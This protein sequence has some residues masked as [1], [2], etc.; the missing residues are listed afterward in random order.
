MQ[1]KQATLLELPSAEGC[2]EVTAPLGE[3]AERV[4]KP[5]FQQI[6]REQLSW[7]SMIVE[8]LIGEGHPARAIW[9]FVGGLDLSGYTRHVRAVEGFAGRPLLNPQ[10]LISLWIYS[11]SQGVGSARSIEKLCE[12]DPA[13]Q[14]LTGME[15]VNAHSLSDF[16]VKH[17]KVLKGLFVQIL[18]LLSAE[19]L[20]TLERVTQD[21]TKI[22]ASAASDSFKGK[23]RIEKALA[24]A[25]QQVTAVDQLSEEESSRRVEKARQRAC[26]E[27][28]DRLER[29]LKQFERS[30]SEGGVKGKEKPK[31]SVTDPEA[32][33]MKQPDGGFAPSFNVQLNT[34][35]ANGLIVA[36]GVTQEGSDINQLT[37]GIERI[38]Q[39]LGTTPKQV[40]ADGGYVSRDNIV[41]MESRQVDFIA[42][43]CDEVGKGKSNYAV[44][45]ISA[46][47]ESSRFIYDAGANS[48]LCPQGKPL[49]YKTK[50][51][52]DSK[53]LYKYCA[54]LADCQN[55][56]AKG[57]C[58][59]GNKKSGR[60]VFRIE[61]L[62]QI[63]QFRQKMET[64]GAKEIYR[65]RSQIA[66]TPN[67]WI[68]A[69]FKLRQFSVRGLKKVGMESIWV[70]L[71]YN[72]C[73][74]IRICWR[75]DNLA[76]KAIV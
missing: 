74:W 13:Y 30:R 58:C 71:T 5:R 70:C 26:R 48:F 27:R 55:C 69:K 12:H 9:D 46:D 65:K 45:G 59:P 21:G 2:S 49:P 60:A 54:N 73:Q 24:A 23:D 39:N 67:L 37:S 8:R 56:V 16:R 61:E 75:K 1:D 43:Q 53:V 57:Q 3:Y 51:E 63:L 36:V 25:R 44:R 29:A 35:A 4:R 28:K 32:R 22:R 11:Y 47:Y 52:E 14:W 19:G 76:V 66:E 40:V 20:I 33:I 62:P 7:R 31:V 72:I 68:K 6:D 64:E 41:E 18:G 10:L 38:E 42:P 34:D 50:Y 15:V 17:E